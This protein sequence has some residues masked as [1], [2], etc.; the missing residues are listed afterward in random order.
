VND[1]QGG[2]NDPEDFRAYIN[3]MHALGYDIQLHVNLQRQ[4]V[5]ERYG[6]TQISS[7]L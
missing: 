2:F 6:D 7:C 4:F 5:D 1:R 3:D